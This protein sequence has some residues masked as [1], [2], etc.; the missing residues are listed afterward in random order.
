MKPVDSS[1]M[2]TLSSST[3]D[4]SLTQAPPGPLPQ[5]DLLIQPLLHRVF[6][7]DREYR[8]Y[9]TALSH[10]GLKNFLFVSDRAP[11]ALEA[12]FRTLR[13]GGVLVW[14]SQ[15]RSR[16]LRMADELAD[17]GFKIERRH[18]SIWRKSRWLPVPLRRVH[19]VVARKVSM[20]LPGEFTDRFTYH[21]QLERFEVNGDNQYVVCK[22]VPSVENVV[23]R[24]RARWPDAA[25]E[26][27]EKRA[28]KFCDKIFPTFLTR[29]A[30]MLLILQEH[31][32]SRYAARVPRAI[33]IEKDI[34]GFV[35]TLRMNWLRVGGQPLSHMEFAL[36]SAD[37]LR[38][39]HDSA[40]V[41][42]LDLRLDNMVITESGVGFVDF[43]SSVRDNE[44]LATN[45]LLDTLFDELM[46]TSHIQK[47]LYSMTQS[48]QVT[49]RHLAA[50][51]GKVDKAI[52][53][54]YLAL[55]FATPHANPDLAGLIHYDPDSDMSRAIHR[56]SQSIL[57]PQD[58]EDTT[59][60]TAKDILRS[61]ELIE[62]DLSRQSKRKN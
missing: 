36:Q 37:L 27:I 43:G 7:D 41:I 24:L 54:F 60:R 12:I 47:M 48:G 17:M 1:A 57:R 20:L 32:P 34:R 21:V 3:P 35:T 23:A 8:R 51:H 2:S 39:V 16:V 55:Q 62:R 14:A 19:Y 50:Q 15:R 52:D 46:R 6:R 30:A 29:E 49:A 45:P 58:P 40:R 13:W 53:L 28:R 44:D 33:D 11:V 38:A 61:L 31:L 26:V 10:D 56:L 22:R 5:D 4:R 18:G 25:A 59:H 42:H 9:G